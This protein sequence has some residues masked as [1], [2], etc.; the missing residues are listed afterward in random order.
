MRASSEGIHRRSE[1]NANKIPGL[2]CS[3]RQR[4]ADKPAVIMDWTGRISAAILGIVPHLFCVYAYINTFTPVANSERGVPIEIKFWDSKRTPLAHMVDVTNELGIKVLAEHNYLNENNIAFSPYGL[5]G[6][7]VALYEGVDGES[8]YQIQRSMQLPWNRNIMRIGFRDIHRTLKTYFVPEEGF[9]AG[10]ALNNEN[11]TF[12]TSYKDILRFYGFDLQNDPLPESA[13]NGNNTENKITEGTTTVTSTA[14]T[15]VSTREETTITESTPSLSTTPNGN[16]EA[17][18]DSNTANLA[19]TQLDSETV[20]TIQDVTTEQSRATEVVTTTTV[21]PTEAETTTVTTES[22]TAS[23][24]TEPNVAESSQTTITDATVQISSTQ[25]ME[26]ETSSDPTTTD[27]TP[28]TINESTLETLQRKKKSIV[29]FVYTSPPYIDDYLLY[30]S[31][32]IGPEI[33]DSDTNSDSMFLV[34]GL[35]NIQVS[36]M[37]YDAVLDHA[38]L[39]HLEASA[40]R[41]PLDSDKYYLLVVLPLKSGTDELNRLLARMARESDLS[42]VYG[43]LRARRVRAVIPSFTVKGHVTLTTDLQKL[44]IR[45]VFEPRQRD[46]TPMTQQSGVYV[47]SIEQAV[48]VAIRKY[49]PDELRKYIPKRNPVVFSATYPFLYF[50]VD[51]SIHVALMAGKMV[52]PLN[53]RIL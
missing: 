9:L 51:S 19:V 6:I 18:S 22:V 15:S 4:T 44:G 50:V 40:L 38:F 25:I 17:T 8:S 48:S 34:N 46:F 16:S 23:A 53:T 13:N 35:R 26:A 1:V 52:D 28:T 7:L 21:V 43:A 42:D 49:Q 45:D 31:F 37:H 11:V 36:Y 3:R 30:R 12:A 24:P 47:R 41:L 27:G 2:T 14:A 32:N 20:T 29:D 39:P 10:L 5:M 33:L